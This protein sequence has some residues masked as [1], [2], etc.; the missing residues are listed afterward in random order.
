MLMA[1]IPGAKPGEQPS[2]LILGP[3]GDAPND[4]EAVAMAMAGGR[5]AGA[6]K[7][8]LNAQPTQRLKNADEAVV[9][10]QQNQDGRSTVRAVEGG[11]R[12]EAAERSASQVAADLVAAEEAALDEVALPPSRREQVRRY[13]AELRKRFE[14]QE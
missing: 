9:A 12:R 11:T 7:A 5:E 4:G 10:A 14:K 6:G 2:A 8:D 13:F 1:P 3:P